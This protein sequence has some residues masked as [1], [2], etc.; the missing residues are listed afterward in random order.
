LGCVC[1]TL[2]LPFTLLTNL[3]R[4]KE[5]LWKLKYLFHHSKNNIIFKAIL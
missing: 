5:E 2:A 4:P 3:L 1:D